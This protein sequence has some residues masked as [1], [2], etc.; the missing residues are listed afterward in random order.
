VSGS[1][2]TTWRVTAGRAYLRSVT[3]PDPR[4][5]RPFSPTYAPRPRTAERRSTSGLVLPGTE[6]TA[7]MLGLTPVSAPNTWLDK[8]ARV[9]LVARDYLTSS[10]TARGRAFDRDQ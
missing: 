7:W 1:R 4:P 6:S 9:Y 5:A 8:L 2:E 10:E 3:N